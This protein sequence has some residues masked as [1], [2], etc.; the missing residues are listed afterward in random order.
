MTLSEMSKIINSEIVGKKKNG[1]SITF[2]IPTGS[3]A[4]RR[5]FAA[6][7]EQHE[8]WEYFEI[9]LDANEDIVKECLSEFID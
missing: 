2:A 4:G 1:K 9:P 5:I 8:I 3:C 6:F 7:G